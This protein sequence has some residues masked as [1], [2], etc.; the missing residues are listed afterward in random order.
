MG[1]QE[2]IE[3]LTADDVA[4]ALQIGRK[5][6]VQVMKRLGAVSVNRRGSLRLPRSAL[7][8]WMAKGE[9]CDDTKMSQPEIPSGELRIVKP[10][11]RAK[12]TA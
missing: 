1:R 8:Q 3:F 5:T 12:T 4:T 11:T 7:F 6:A 10:R 9:P 2:A